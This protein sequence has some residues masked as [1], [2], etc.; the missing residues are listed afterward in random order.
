MP[1][2]VRLSN[3]YHN[4]GPLNR[5]TDCYYTRVDAYETLDYTPPRCLQCV[6]PSMGE[7]F[8]II[9]YIY[10]K[11]NAFVCVRCVNARGNSLKFSL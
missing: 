9:P 6:E 1:P 2:R 5:I 10:G 8:I 4:I 11:L 3:T 7:I